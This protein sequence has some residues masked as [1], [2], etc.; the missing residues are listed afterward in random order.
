MG[1]Y[2]RHILL[3]HGCLA[4]VRILRVICC[5]TKPAELEKGGVDDPSSPF[6]LAGHEE[7]HCG[8]NLIIH[9]GWK[10]SGEALDSGE[11]WRCYDP[12]IVTRGNFKDS[13]GLKV[14][15]VVRILLSRT[16]FCVHMIP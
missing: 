13:S 2:Q 15:K 16:M 6:Y 1:F 14:C 5:G 10:N 11:H 7:G 4:N 3:G 12:R 8:W 9:K